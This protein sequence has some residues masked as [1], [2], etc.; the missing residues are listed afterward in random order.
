MRNLKLHYEKF[1]DNNI[2]L[3]AFLSNL[4]FGIGEMITVNGLDYVITKKS[5]IRIATHT[6]MKAFTCNIAELETEDN[7]EKTSIKI[8]REFEKLELK[9]LIGVKDTD[10]FFRHLFVME[11]IKGIVSC[12]YSSLYYIR[13]L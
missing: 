13:K 3:N 4:K 10:S 6:D 7:S 1:I 5:F 2:V 12:M 11:N 9:K 8:G